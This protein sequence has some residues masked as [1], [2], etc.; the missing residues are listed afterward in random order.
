MKER[1]FML[2]KLRQVAASF[3]IM[4]GFTQLY[5]F[6][7]AV[8]GYFMS[9]SGNYNFVWNYWVIGL[10]ALLLIVSGAVMIQND[11]FRLAVAT[12]LLAYTAF[13]AFSVYFYQIQPLLDKTEDIQ[14]PF[15]Y[16]NS[17]LAVISLILF[18]VFLFNKNG[19]LTTELNQN[20]SW[21]RKWLV[22]S[23]IFLVASAGLTIWLSVII[24]QH[25]QNPKVSDAYIF[26][27]DFDAVFACVSTVLLLIAAASSLKR[28]S[29][30]MAGIVL[31]IGFL[32]LSNYTWFEQWMNFA[33]K[34]GYDLAE[35]ENRLFGIQFVVGISGFLSGLLILIGKK[36]K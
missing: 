8:Y 21:K 19:L 6:S 18:F 10:F 7:S 22:T 16:T 35:N 12:I 17:I 9:D 14:G 15:N 31:G 11:I 13:Q 5:S 2:Q 34:N 3:T 4:I 25:F 33:I 26:T 1:I 23:V 20:E 30:F 32:Y 29:Y 24:I 27:N 28:G 36:S